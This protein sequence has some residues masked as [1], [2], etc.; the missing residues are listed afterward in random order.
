MKQANVKMLLSALAPCVSRISGIHFF[1]KQVEPHVTCPI[2]FQ[3][4]FL[5]QLESPD[6][7]YECTHL[8]FLFVFLLSSVK[9]LLVFDVNSGQECQIH[10]ENIYV[11]NRFQL[12]SGRPYTA[13]VMN[14]ICFNTTSDSLSTLSCLFG[15]A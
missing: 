11:N 2:M 9:C 6:L 14:Q 13:I 5:S 8:L 3:N 4:L 1:Y 10:V 12:Q 15:V 7:I